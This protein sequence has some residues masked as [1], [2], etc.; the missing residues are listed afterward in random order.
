MI[1]I[2]PTNMTRPKGALEVR[3]GWGDQRREV[4]DDEQEM[5]ELQRLELGTAVTLLSTV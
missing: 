2:A 4:G 5:R 1:P 3:K